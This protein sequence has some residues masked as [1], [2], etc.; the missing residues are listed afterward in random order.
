MGDFGKGT[1]LQLKLWWQ[2]VQVSPD[3][4]TGRCGSDMGC[5]LEPLKCIYKLDTCDYVL[6]W[7][8]ENTSIQFELTAKLSHRELWAAVGLNDKRKMVSRHVIY[9]SLILLQL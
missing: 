9:L 3:I 2:C 1:V 6:T 5:Y 8:T 4:D 7:H